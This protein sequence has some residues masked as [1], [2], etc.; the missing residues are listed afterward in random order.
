M[1]SISRFII[2]IAL[3]FATDAESRAFPLAE[4]NHAQDLRARQVATSAT[5]TSTN[6]GSEVASNILGAVA[7]G[8]SVS[9]ASVAAASASVASVASN[10]QAEDSICNADSNRN[11]TAWNDFD[12]GD[13]FKNQCVNVRNPLNHGGT[14]YDTGPNLIPSATGTT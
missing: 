13:W 4:A 1:P 14:K 9:S 8:A 7:A 6:I 12:M 3:V 5:A 2:S 11:Q 10:L